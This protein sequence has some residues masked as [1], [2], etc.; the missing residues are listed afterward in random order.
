MQKRSSS[1]ETAS[2]NPVTG[3]LLG[4]WPLHSVKRLCEMVREARA[5]QP[6]WA[7]LSVKKRAAYFYAVRRYI[8]E[9]ADQLAQTIAHDNGKLRLDALVTEILPAAL[10]TSYYCRKAPRFLRTRRLA[11][12]NIFF[13][14]KRSKVARRPYGV[15]GIISPWNYPFAIPFSEVIMGLLAGNAVILKTAS[16]TQMVGRALKK[17]FDY[18][19]LPKGLFQFINLPGRQA[20]PGFLQCGVDKL[21]FTGSVAVGKTLMRL[22]AD[23][24]TPLNL[25]LGGNDAMIVCREA[26]L[27]RAVNGAVWAGF[28]NAGQS[29][30]GVERIY[31]QEDIYE[32]FLQRLKE[33]V[34]NLRI[35]YDTDFNTDMGAMTTARQMESVRHQMDEALSK[36]AKIFARSAP[37]ENKKYKNFLPAIVLTEVN[38]QMQVMRDETFGPLVCVMKF[39]TAQQAVQWANDS[40]LGLTASVWSAKRRKAQRLAGKI[41]AG[42][43]TINDHLMSHGLPETSW[44]GFKQS[45]IGRSHGEL[46]FME[47][48]QAQIIVDDRLDRLK[49]DLWWPPY[50]ADVYKGIKGVLTFLYGRGLFKRLRALVDLLGIVSRLFK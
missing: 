14:N 38:H 44:G 22:A 1:I 10:A 33:K 49:K 46:G 34:E 25:E 9:N 36:G 2:F 30:G 21:F 19:R 13:L 18:A 32:P 6:R 26:N 45:G 15:L 47:M 20:G 7:G 5:V 39:K 8:T 12:A 41:Q 24:L 27:E 48:T 43:V 29:C 31:V 4:R 17:V 50:S 35:G 11:S 37:P 16:E 3:E 28:S 42:V 40:Y 23:S